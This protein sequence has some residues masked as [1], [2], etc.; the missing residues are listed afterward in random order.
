MYVDGF[1]MAVVNFSKFEFNFFLNNNNLKV[2]RDVM[3]HGTFI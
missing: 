1:I 2:A 3:H